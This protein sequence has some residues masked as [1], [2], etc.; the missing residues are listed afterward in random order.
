MP[1]RIFA[2]T[3]LKDLI[4]AIKSLADALQS[5]STQELRSNHTGFLKTTG[6]ISQA[7]LRR[8]LM[9]ARFE[10]YWRGVQQ[11]D[12]PGDVKGTYNQ[13]AKYEPTNPYHEK[14]MRVQQ[15]YLP[16]Y[17]LTSPYGA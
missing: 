11:V 2:Y 10:I 6:P 15:V 13:C 7:D 1:E 8:R 14:K 5:G 17:F 12:A 3:Q 9:E 4:P 16:P